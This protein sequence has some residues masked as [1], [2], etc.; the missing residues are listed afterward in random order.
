MM[1]NKD[2]YKILESLV[3]IKKHNSNRKN[4]R[5]KFQAARYNKEDIKFLEDNG[6]AKTTLL[7]EFQT[8]NLGETELKIRY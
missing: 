5:A 7:G 8:T 6:F 1:L 3:D 4:I 2:Q